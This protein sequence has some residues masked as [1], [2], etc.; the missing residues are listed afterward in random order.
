MAMNDS[1][2]PVLF[3]IAAALLPVL[4]AGQSG[5]T[6]FQSKV[7]QAHS[8]EELD[9]FLDLVQA[10][11]PKEMLVLLTQFRDRLPESE[12]IPQTYRIEM[13]A[14]SGMDQYELAMKAGERALEL[15][16]DDVDVLLGLANMLARDA[17]KPM[18]A[19][20]DKAERYAQRALE[21]IASLRASRSSPPEAW[22]RQTDHM[23]SS[24]HSALGL[25]AL[26]RG[27]YPASI[28]EFETSVN[29]NPAAEGAQYYMLGV[30]YRL[31]GNRSAAVVAFRR[32]SE[33]GP[34]PVR[35]RAQNALLTIKQE[36]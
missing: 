17:S 35:V 23:K 13:D 18:D 21:R 2:A 20:L 26:K 24:A 10:S 30:A 33:L 32:A 6:V 15:N 31:D 4:L 36:R 34:D 11:D 29:Q 27:R 12:F 28:A 3:F 14:H 5:L 19:I 25:I 16:P 1:S 8:R 9:R 22:Q 7:P